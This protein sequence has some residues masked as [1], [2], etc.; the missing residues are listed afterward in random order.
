MIIMNSFSPVNITIN[1]DKLKY[2]IQHSYDL[3]K[4]KSID[5]VFVSK[6]ICGDKNIL[7]A[8]EET[9]VKI[10][11]DSRL[12]NF[13]K[14]NTTKTKMLIRPAVI[15]EADALVTLTDISFQTELDTIKALEAAALN[16]SK[17]HDILLMID[18]GDLR[19]GIQYTDKDKIWDTATYIHESK[20]L[21]LVGVAANYNCFLGLLPDTDNMTTLAEVFNLLKPLY[22]TDKPILSGGT[23]SSVSLLTNK[24]AFIPSEISQ[25]RMGEA[26]MLGRDPADNT[27]IDGYATDVFTLEVPIIEVHK[28]KLSDGT[29]M[30]RGVLSIGK[31]DLQTDRI[32]PYD[33]RIKI[34]GACSDECVIDLSNAPEYK[35]GDI[36]KFMLEYGA[37]MTSFA[38]QF[39]NKIY[40]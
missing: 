34:L 11:A 16:Q 23:S 19:D 36:V 35:S 15:Q 39:I 29:E 24:D 13:A 27:F 5:L 10:I 28:K 30:L 31:Q 12:D 33:E 38:G 7:A 4:E 32:I 21:R 17:I 20:N 1:L 9:P 26:I 40:I 18:I 22:D 6:S 2:N 37:L 14:M 8:V 25:I 3:C